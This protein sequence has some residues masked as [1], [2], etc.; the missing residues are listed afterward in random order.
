MRERTT[1][2][3]GRSYEDAPNRV[4][5]KYKSVEIKLYKTSETKFI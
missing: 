1:L 3:R 4:K 2:R 5:K